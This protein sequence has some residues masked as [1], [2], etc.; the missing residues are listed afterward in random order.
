MEKLPREV[1]LEPRNTSQVLLPPELP[2]RSCP[3]H[4]Q[5]TLQYV[6]I[7]IPSHFLPELIQT[8]IYYQGEKVPPEVG[9]K[10]TTPE[11]LVGCNHMSYPGCPVLTTTYRLYSIGIRILGMGIPKNCIATIVSRYISQYVSQDLT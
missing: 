11:T 7:C 4:H 9:L 1:G 6:W 8:F 2:G 3:N 10:P 5:Q